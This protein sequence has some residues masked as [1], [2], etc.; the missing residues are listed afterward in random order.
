MKQTVSQEIA[1]RTMT[2]ETG[3]LALQADGAVTIRFGD[4]IVICAAMM[5]E[6]GNSDADFFPLTI[7]YQERFYA[8]G[9]IKGSRFIKRDGRASDEVVLKAR[10]I[11]RPIRPLFPKGITNEVQGMATVLSADLVNECGVLALTGM[12]AAMMVAGMPFSGPLAGVR[13]GMKE[14]KLIVFPTNEETETGTLDLIVAGTAD[15]ITM[16]E[17]GAVEV[18]E[19]TMLEALELAHKTI[20]EICA[21]QAKLVDLIKPE[22]RTYVST[23]PSDDILT[24]ISGIISADELSSVK[25]VKKHDIKTRVHELQAKVKEH[26]ASQI[27]DETYTEEALTSA[28]QKLIDEN[29]RKNILEKETRIDGRALADVRTISGEVGLMPRT[30]G[31]ALFQ[32]GETQ[33][34]TLTTLGAPGAAQIIDSMEA[35]MEKRYI[36][37]YVFPPY[38]VGEVKAVRGPSRREIGHGALAE[39]ALRPMIPAKEDF[40]YTIMLMSEIMTCNGSSSMA[41]VCGSTL[42]LMDAGVPIKKPVSAVAMGLV[43]SKELKETGK[44][45]YKILTDIQSFEDFAGDMDFKVAGTRDGITALQMDIKVK[46]ITPDM[47]RE[48]MEKAKVAR[49]FILD[50]MLK[51]LAEPRKQLSQYAPIILKIQINPDFIRDV[52]GKGGETIQKITAE[53]GVEIDIEQTGLVIITAPNAEAGEKAKKWI[54]QIT[55]EPNVG[56]EFDGTV[57]NIMDFGAFVEIL[58]GKDGLVHI[59]ALRPF[60]VDKVGDVVKVGDKVHVKLIKIDEQG[61]LNLSMKEFYKEEGK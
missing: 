18:S 43:C 56:D 16:V 10:L 39:R 27:E 51:V 44:G 9:K 32:R 11:D 15:A 36:H 14:G 54:D 38:S 57:V 25:G 47:M 45:P 21:L 52:I 8:A 33:A 7:E 55:Y 34:L 31:S 22:I 5:A 37:Y 46:G 53:C 6:E 42:S 12:S 58:P 28:L 35:D 29:M 1:G 49:N 50:E 17:A 23:K 59:S 4:S 3:K 26:F 19:E 60:R 41:S 24:A 2:L 30:H 13:I 48:A 20:K 61:R 40:P